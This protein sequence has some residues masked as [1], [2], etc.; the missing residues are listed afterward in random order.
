ME[1]RT[2]VKQ[3]E[4]NSHALFLICIFLMGGIKTAQSPIAGQ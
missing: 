4:Q 2:S 1:E 3:A